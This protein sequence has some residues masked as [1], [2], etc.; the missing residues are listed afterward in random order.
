[1][2]STSHDLHL[3][4]FIFEII[5]YF[6]FFILSLPIKIKNKNIFLKI[7]DLNKLYDVYIFH[8]DC[9]TVRGNLKG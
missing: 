7:A 8:L 3:Q 5:E 4:P 9:K 2:M 6:L 1:M